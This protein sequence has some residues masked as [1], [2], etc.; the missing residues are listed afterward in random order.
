M[1]STTLT[2]AIQTKVS[3]QEAHVMSFKLRQIF[4]LHVRG[5]VKTNLSQT[6][7]TAKN[8]LFQV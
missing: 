4:F 7:R 1:C 8:A 2:F 3:Q 5:I 6:D